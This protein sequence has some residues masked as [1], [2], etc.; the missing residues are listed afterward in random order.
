[1]RYRALVA[2]IC[3]ICFALALSPPAIAA[4]ESEGGEG[5]YGKTDD[6]VI[7]NFGFGL[8]IFFVL[9][10]TVLSIGQHLLAKRKQPK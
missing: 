10:V 4:L 6:V 5:A 1:M 9:L 7:T 2:A 8:I 3:T